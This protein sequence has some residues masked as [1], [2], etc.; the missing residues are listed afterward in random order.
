MELEYT[1]MSK[2]REIINDFEKVI[3]LNSSP[4]CSTCDKSEQVLLSI[5]DQL[6]GVT[7]LKVNSIDSSELLSEI[8]IRSN[9]TLTFIK[10]GLKQTSLITNKSDDILS[11]YKIHFVSSAYKSAGRK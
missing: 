5:K 3:M 1:S 8:G 9:G 6:H 10:N 7:L 2:S 11:L 4:G